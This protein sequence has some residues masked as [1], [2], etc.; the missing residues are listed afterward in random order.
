VAITRITFYLGTV[1]NTKPI[2]EIPEGVLGAF[3]ETYVA[4]DQSIYLRHFLMSAL[5]GAQEVLVPAKLLMSSGR[6]RRC[7]GT[8]F[9][10]C[11]IECAVQE[12]INAD[13]VWL[14]TTRRHQK[15]SWKVLDARESEVIS[16]VDA[17]FR[18]QRRAS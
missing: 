9:K 15:P 11:Q 1:S 17:V 5:F 8:T 7:G 6:F 3:H 4:N 13:G 14:P 2:I 16:T 10:L 18:T 12:I